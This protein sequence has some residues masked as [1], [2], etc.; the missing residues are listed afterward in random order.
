VTTQGDTI[1]IEPAD[2]DVVYV[3]AYDPWLV[4]GA[5]IVAYPG[6]YPVPGIFLG[7]V[8]IGFGIGFGVGFFGDLGGA[9]ITGD[10]IGMAVQR[11]TTTTLMS[12]IAER[13]SIAI[14]QSR[15]F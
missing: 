15:Q 9:G 13:S 6:W 10:T 7:G 2:P 5:P 14:T 8:G 4:Y 11:Y 3:P 12:R 1:I